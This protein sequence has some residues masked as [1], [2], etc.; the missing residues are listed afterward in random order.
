MWMLVLFGTFVAHSVFPHFHH[1]HTDIET[2]SV[3]DHHHHD[4]GEDHEHTGAD[5]SS[6]DEQHH[7]GPL[8]LNFGHHTHASYNADYT[9]EAKRSIQTEADGKKLVSTIVVYAQEESIIDS[10][11]KEAPPLYKDFTLDN[12]FLLSSSL[13][14]PPIIG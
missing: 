6:E 10:E 3:E 13:K 2:V 5:N 1:S 8:D 4:D 12:P 9:T 11:K 7:E 14:A